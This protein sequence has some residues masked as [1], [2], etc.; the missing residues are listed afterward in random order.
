MSVDLDTLG[1]LTLSDVCDGAAVLDE[2]GGA[3]VDSSFQVPGRAGRQIDPAGELAPL[4]LRVEFVPK[5]TD[6]G[7]NPG[8][9]HL[10]LSKIKAQ[11]RSRDE[12]ALV[13]TIDNIGQLRAMVKQFAPMVEQAPSKYVAN[14]FCASGSWQD[15]T[16][17]SATGTPPTVVTGG[18]TEIHDPR[19]E[20]SAAGETEITLTDGTVYTITA[21]AGPVYPIT[22]DPAGSNGEG[23]VT[24]A[25][26]DDALGE[27]TFSHEHWL[28]LEAD[29]DYSAGP[30]QGITA[31]NAVTL[32]WRNRWG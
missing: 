6:S 2:G 12:V 24:D 7:G 30:P 29:V 17:D 11:L 14:L 19:L 13:R 21:A 16:E 8:F 23:T 22:V 32:Y 31:D 26:G 10:N 3:Y 25:N 28:R 27:V 1:S 9:G 18:D 15:V 20:I 5:Y 4:I